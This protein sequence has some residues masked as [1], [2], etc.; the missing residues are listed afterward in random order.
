MDSENTLSSPDSQDTAHCPTPFGDDL[1][2]AL[3]D[4][5]NSFSWNDGERKA[6]VAEWLAFIHRP[7]SN[8]E[9][10]RQQILEYATFL[11]QRRLKP[12]ENPVEAIED[13]RTSQI[14]DSG[15]PKSNLSEVKGCGR[16]GNP[17]F[18]TLCHSAAVKALKDAPFRLLAYLLS[19]GDSDG[20]NCFPSRRRIRGDLDWSESKV[21][22]WLKRLREEGWIEPIR[23]MKKSGMHT[24]S[25]YRFRIP[26][27]SMKGEKEWLEGALR[28]SQR[29]GV[30]PDEDN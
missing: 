15:I 22:R 1:Q 8:P 14:D 10:A 16:K 28:W 17:K 26:P 9:K 18:R 5:W 13:D 21:Y 30:L 23:F 3:G 27:S 12:K 24:S 29:V 2:A 4:E 11:K 25:L 6:L 19:L 7:K 20:G